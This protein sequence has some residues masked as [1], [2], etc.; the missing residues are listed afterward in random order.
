MNI[1]RYKIGPLHNFW[2]AHAR[3]TFPIHIIPPQNLGY[4]KNIIWNSAQRLLHNIHKP[5]LIH[6]RTKL[7]YY[8]NN[9]F[10]LLA[11]KRMDR[12]D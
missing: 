3:A 6:L 5:V 10:S 4:S 8:Y 1:W 12:T 9:A 11:Y 2:N 7:N